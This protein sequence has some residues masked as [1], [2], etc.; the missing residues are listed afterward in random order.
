MAQLLREWGDMYLSGE[1]RTP[2][3]RNSIEVKNPA[4]RSVFTEVPAGTES[5][6]NEAYQS[7]SAAQEAWAARPAN[8]RENIIKG[9]MEALENNRDDIIELLAIESG[10][11][12]LASSIEI[13]ST[14]DLMDVS[15]ELRAE[16]QKDESNIVGKENIVK[17]DPVGVVGVITPWNF[18]LYLS[19]RAVA[20]AL[21]LGNSV[22]LKPDEHTPITGGLLIAH[23]F[24]IAGLPSG[25]LNV[26]SG[27]G[28]EIGDAV[29]S[30]SVPRVIS[31]TGS[32]EV[33]QRVARLAAENFAKPSLELGGNNV[34]LVTDEADLDL[35]ASSGAFASFTHQGQVCISINR[36]LVHESLYDEYVD[37]LVDH[38]QSLTVGDPRESKHTLGPLINETQRDEVVKFIR[39]AVDEGATLQT[40][41]GYDELFVEPTVLS[42]VTPDMAV[43]CNEHFGPVAPVLPFETDEEAIRIANDTEYGL[44]GAVH[45]QDIDRARQIADELETGSVHVN[46][47]PMNVGTTAPFGGVKNSGFG[48]FNG[49]WVRDEFT[50]TKWVSVQHE[51]RD[52]MVF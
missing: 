24:E 6:I 49:E 40:G 11:V 5:D 46:D 19:M 21:A 35:A 3:N 30:H 7:A 27:Y 43:S 23:L 50:Q 37:R 28:S 15:A 32:T 31:F 41:G 25:V 22:V 34:H 14:L 18:P 12:W 38:A 44:S 42:E 2:D 13:E 36:H 33:G 20:P 29:S 45:S 8:E 48:R 16:T 26:V 17:R 9:A 10:K 51:P 47:Q 52:Y 39:T 1:W 4:T